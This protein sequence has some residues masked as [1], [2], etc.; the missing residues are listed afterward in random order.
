MGQATA[1]LPDP[2]AT[3]PAGPASTDDLLAQLAGEEIERL[4]AETDTVVLPQPPETPAPAPTLQPASASTS[5]TPTI[6]EAPTPAKAASAPSAA[7]GEDELEALFTQLDELNPGTMPSAGKPAAAPSTALGSTE[8]PS[9]ADA[10]AAEMAEDAAQHARPM[11]L[12]G[13]AA[14]AGPNGFT[15]TETESV[16]TSDSPSIF[17]RLLAAFSAPLDSCPD[18]I[19]DLVGKIAILT[20]LN[21]MCVLAYVIFFRR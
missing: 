14:E 4:L 12:K 5:A 17:V 6:A 21:A 3:S 1:D 20:M 2:L 8:E 19:R 18:H 7:P 13:A 16:E 10:L 11:S 15:S 9:A